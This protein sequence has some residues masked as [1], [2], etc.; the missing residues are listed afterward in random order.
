MILSYAKVLYPIFGLLALGSCKKQKT[1]STYQIEPSHMTTL[2]SAE[3]NISVSEWTLTG[4]DLGLEN[5]FGWSVNMTSLEGGKQ[6]GVQLIEVDNGLLKIT[7]VPTRGMSIHSVKTEETLLGWDSPVKEIVHPCFINLE[8]NNGLGWL[9]G[10]NEWMVRCGMEF[11]GHPGMDQGRMLTLH[12]NIGNIPASEVQ[13]VVDQDPP[14]R[15][16]IRGKV[17]EVWFNGPDLQLWTEIS[18]EPGSNSFRIDDVLTNNSLAD[19]EFM[20]L[21]HANFG[22]PLLE[23]G[24]RL[25]GTIGRVV[26]FDEFAAS[27]VNNWHS[28]SE[29]IL[30]IAER[31]NCIY[32]FADS[33]GNAHFILQ[34]ATGDRAVSFS[35]PLNQLPYF[36][37][38]KNMD[39]KGYVTG[40]EPGTGFP[41]NRSVERKYGRVPILEPGASRAFNLEYSIHSDKE[42]IKSV[43]EKIANLST[44]DVEV[45]TSVIGK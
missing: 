35:Y 13:V 21:Y 45:T 27:D 7:V 37:Q 23:K 39:S 36:T 40:L 15:I 14:H 20:V 19:Q 26:P 16:R 3:R 9:D 10:F 34:N 4:Q 41:H 38:W 22:A 25:F 30:N 6:Q 11:A 29:P 24:S 18:T 33:E 8:A 44:N 17:R 1:L 42:E 2:I 5:D 32:P 28:Y 43:V 12:G 31:V